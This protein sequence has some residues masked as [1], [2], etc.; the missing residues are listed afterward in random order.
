MREMTIHG[1][2]E[3]LALN[4]RFPRLGALKE[5]LVKTVCA[6]VVCVSLVLPAS[7]AFAKPEMHSKR[8]TQ[9]QKVGKKQAANSSGLDEDCKQLERKEK[10]DSLIRTI[11]TGDLKAVKKAAGE[12]NPVINCLSD[13]TS[14]ATNRVVGRIINNVRSHLKSKDDGLKMKGLVAFAEIQSEYLRDNI[15]GT[16]LPYNDAFSA[17]IKLIDSQ[18]EGKRA[19]AVKLAGELYMPFAELDSKQ[20]KKVIRKLES[21]LDDDKLGYDALAALDSYGD[22][23]QNEP[24]L[25]KV[26]ESGNPRM[27][28]KAFD[29]LISRNDDPPRHEIIP[30]YVSLLGN[31]DARISTIA[32]KALSDEHFWTYVWQFNQSDIGKTKSE[33]AA[34]T[35]HKNEK[36]RKAAAAILGYKKGMKLDLGI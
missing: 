20:Q 28:S 2:Q 14:N 8:D 3:K 11:R 18:D 6:T 9:T 25:K 23:Y 5:G 19:T 15:E 22:D 36:V 13:D 27:S 26:I 35:N 7:S 33:L 34:L 1:N 17:V 10:I 30:Y 4:T 24:K 12:F 21:L 32:K 31:P 16:S 29:I